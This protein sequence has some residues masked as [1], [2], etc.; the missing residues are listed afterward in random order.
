MVE[1]VDKT[2]RE[3]ILQELKK[4]N[5]ELLEKCLAVEK[6]YLELEKQ[7]LDLEKKNYDLTKKNQQILQIKYM[8]G[9]SSDDDGYFSQ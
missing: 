3:Q 6:Q 7:Q 2:S 9:Y 5:Q 8:F 1:S 4:K